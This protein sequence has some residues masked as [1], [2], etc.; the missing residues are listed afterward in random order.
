MLVQ[1]PGKPS[2]EWPSATCRVRSCI[3]PA[4]RWRR[5]MFS[6]SIILLEPYGGTIFPGSEQSC[7]FR[8]LFFEFMIFSIKSVFLTWTS[9]TIRTLWPPFHN[10]DLNSQRN[11]HFY[12]FYWLWKFGANFE[13]PVLRCFRPARP[14]WDPARQQSCWSYII[15]DTSLTNITTQK[16]LLMICS[17]QY[18]N[19]I[20]L[21]M[22]FNSRNYIFWKL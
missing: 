12:D 6:S 15:C 5:N 4:E 3:F 16:Q 7:R 11:V 1:L 10:G 9:C 2:S 21:M 14:T 22:N 13:G 18:W 17:I 8:I 20:W 19:S